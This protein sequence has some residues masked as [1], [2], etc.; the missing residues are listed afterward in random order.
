MQ[1]PGRGPT[2]KISGFADFNL[3]FGDDANPLIFPLDAKAHD[4]FQFGELD[5]FVSSQLSRTV[6]FL[7]GNCFRARR[8]I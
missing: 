8:D 4:T 6:S 7:G 5:L 1:L 3:E 2:L